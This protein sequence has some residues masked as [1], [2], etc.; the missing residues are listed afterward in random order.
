MVFNLSSAGAG[1]SAEGGVVGG[2]E[3]GE[4]GGLASHLGRLA[5]LLPDSQRCT[6]EK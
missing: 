2:G 3:S 5:P 4:M 6:L 1:V